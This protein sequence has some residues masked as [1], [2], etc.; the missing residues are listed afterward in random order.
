M[1][2]EPG[3]SQFLGQ[4]GAGNES[5]SKT[6]AVPL[7]SGPT[8]VEADRVTIVFSLYQID[9][10]S[11]AD[12]FFVVINGIAIDLGEMDSTSMSVT[13]TGNCLLYTSPSPRD[14]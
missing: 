13:E 14:S 9:N 5:T 12:K 1:V 8:P 11:P 6:V 4:L 3:F 7:S 2:D 10:W